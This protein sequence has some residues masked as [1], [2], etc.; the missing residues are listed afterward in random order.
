MSPRAY[1]LGGVVAVLELQA[2]EGASLSFEGVTVG[3]GRLSGISQIDP[4]RLDALGR[5]VSPRGLLL[6]WPGNGLDPDGSGA[7][8]LEILPYG[9]VVVAASPLVAVHDGEL[10][11]PEAAGADSELDVA[12]SARCGKVPV[13]GAMP[14]EACASM[15]ELA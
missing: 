1:I 2:V 11:G 12:R 6:V 7:F 14:L 13:Q 3:L 4:R 5:L 8:V 15:G 10:A 9:D